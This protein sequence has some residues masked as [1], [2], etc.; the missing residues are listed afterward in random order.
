MPKVTVVTTTIYVPT[1]L[2]AYAEN[3]NKFGHEVDYIVVGDRKTPPEAASFCET[4]DKC[5]FVG[6]D[7]Q[8]EFSWFLPENSIARRNIGHL[9]AYKSGADVIIMLDDDN[10][11]IADQDFVAA[12]AK[13]GTHCELPSMHSSN[14]WFNVCDSLREQHNVQFY[15]RGFPPSKRWEQPEI[16]IIEK[17]A[18]IAVNAGLWSNDPDI[19][20]I[21]RL[22]RK[23][24]TVGFKPRSF[25]EFSLFPCTWSPWNCQ[26]TAISRKALPSYFL[27]PYIGRHLDIWASYI[28]T[29][30]VEAQGEVIAFGTPLAFHE[31]SPHNLYNDLEQELPW[32]RMTDEFCDT[33]RQI[34]VPNTGYLDG[35]QAVIEGLH[36]KWNTNSIAKV[37]YLEG[38][39]TWHH[40]CTNL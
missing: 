25:T 6:V 12:H 19:D 27:S 3:A 21:T 31:R 17:G 22:E 18:T 24:V 26:N 14:G 13:T 15:A 38:L 9:M 23:L 10:L 40:I 7:D 39:S 20:A 2:K 16:S 34:E 29:R 5:K 8:R 30:I 4:I 35:L 11:S 32:I 36:A 28:T 1:F 37:K 33:L